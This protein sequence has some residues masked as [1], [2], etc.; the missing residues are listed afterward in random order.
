V[1]QQFPGGPALLALLGF[2]LVAAIAVIGYYYWR[3]RNSEA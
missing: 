3:R 2:L 1:A